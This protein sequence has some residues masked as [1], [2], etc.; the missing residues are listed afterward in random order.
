MKVDPPPLRLW[1]EAIGSVG[2][3]T[4]A[5]DSERAVGWRP[6]SLLPIA[7]N[8]KEPPPPSRRSPKAPMETT[9]IKTAASPIIQAAETG[10]FR[11]PGERR[12]SDGTDWGAGKVWAMSSRASATSRADAGRSAGC[13]AIN[14]FTR[15]ATAGGTWEFTSPRVAGLAGQ[16]P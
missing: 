10:R 1:P 3:G 13:F 4:I 5:R 8:P 15:L 9:A 6:E 14:R 7:P 11:L 2:T 16:R 12:R